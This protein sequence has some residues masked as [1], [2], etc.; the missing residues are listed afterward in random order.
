MFAHCLAALLLNS[1]VAETVSQRAFDELGRHRLILPD[2]GSDAPSTVRGRHW[3]SAS[4]SSLREFEEHSDRLGGAT[5]QEGGSSSPTDHMV[6]NINC[7]SLPASTRI[8]TAHSLTSPLSAPAPIEHR[9]SDYCTQP[10]SLHTRV[11][12]PPRTAQ[13]MKMEQDEEKHLTSH[14]KSRLEAKYPS[15]TDEDIA[16]A[17]AEGYTQFAAG[18][19]DDFVPPAVERTAEKKLAALTATQHERAESLWPQSPEPPK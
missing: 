8:A 16:A 2:A 18:R 17:L 13:N 6:S 4:G 12:L 14:A 5:F 11:E 9:W 19:A 1:L 10:T 15:V 3:G 7:N